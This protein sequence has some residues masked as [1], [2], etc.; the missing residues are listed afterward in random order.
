LARRHAAVFG[1]GLGAE[2]LSILTWPALDIPIQAD[3]FFDASRC[4]ELRLL[5]A[6]HAGRR[7]ARSPTLRAT[8]P[9]C[10]SQPPRHDERGPHNARR[11]HRFACQNC[12][13]RRTILHNDSPGQWHFRND[14]RADERLVSRVPAPPGSRRRFLERVPSPLAW[15]FTPVAPRRSRHGRRAVAPPLPQRARRK[16]PNP[17]GMINASPGWSLTRLVLLFDQ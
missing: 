11:K 4:V 2:H 5:T 15:R 7:L 1:E 3:R 9:R 6:S 14:Y 16:L 8:L 12:P 10:R 13:G 17:W